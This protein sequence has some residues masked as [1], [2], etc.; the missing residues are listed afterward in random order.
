MKNILK[1]IDYLEK[2][3]Y[4]TSIWDFCGNFY[5]SFLSNNNVDSGS[6]LQ[7]FK[8]LLHWSGESDESLVIDSLFPKDVYQKTT[9]EILSV[10][11]K[12]VDNLISENLDEDIFYNELFTKICDDILFAEEIEKICAITVLVLN[13]KIPYFKL[14][15]AMKMD[16]DKYQEI[17]SSLRGEIQKA[18]FALQYG[19]TQKTELS[20][21]L[22][23]IVKTQKKDEDRIV[24]IANILGFYDSQIKVL[25]D[26]LKENDQHKEDAED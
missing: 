5:R 22:Y 1:P 19:Y 4:K 14:G 10:V 11:K 25:Y 24:L 6:K 9:S 18:Y 15:K 23:S 26:R 8:L 21:Q 12:I 17:S 3:N 7:N 13:P 20:S 2:A 16:N